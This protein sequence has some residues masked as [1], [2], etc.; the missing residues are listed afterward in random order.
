L[1]TT[2]QWVQFLDK[3]THDITT[4]CYFYLN[5]TQQP[6]EL[7][8]RAVELYKRLMK[9]DGDFVWLFLVQLANC[10]VPITKPSLEFKDIA[11][12]PLNPQIARDYQKNVNFILSS[13][14]S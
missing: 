11:I 8:Q 14:H 7:Q 9:N 3:D 1:I 13:D 6:P 5:S 10:T 2:T 12:T 4:T